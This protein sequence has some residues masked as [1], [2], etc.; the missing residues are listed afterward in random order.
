M[1]PAGSRTGS[2]SVPDVADVAR[3]E[4]QRQACERVFRQAITKKPAE[5]RMGKGKASRGLVAVIKPA[6]CSSRSKA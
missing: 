2:S 4:A 1:K 6:A 5:T 3:D